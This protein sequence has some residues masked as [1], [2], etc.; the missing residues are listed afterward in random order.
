LLGAA[1]SL[2]RL[3]DLVMATFFPVLRLAGRP[4]VARFAAA[5]LLGQVGERGS[6]AGAVREDHFCLAFLE[7][8]L[9]GSIRAA[10]PSAYKLVLQL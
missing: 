1:T 4:A 8:A 6:A 2:N 9:A 3:A 7:A 5:A 10:C